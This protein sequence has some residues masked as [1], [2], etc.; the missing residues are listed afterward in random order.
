MNY[1]LHDVNVK[2]KASKMGKR[3]LGI[4]WQQEK[5]FTKAVGFIHSK[6]CVKSNIGGESMSAW[7]V[8][9]IDVTYNHTH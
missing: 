2:E 3:Y 5:K 1:H 4:D 6:F 9:E 8:G 7:P